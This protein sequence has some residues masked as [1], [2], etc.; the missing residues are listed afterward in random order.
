MIGIFL[1]AAADAVNA[2]PD[3]GGDSLWKSGA[4]ALG[5]MLLMKLF[6][7]VSGWID[8]KGK[9]WINEHF[10]QLQEKLNSNALLAQI[11]ADDAV[12]GILEASIPEVLLELSDTAQNDLKNGKFD[13]VDWQ[14]IGTRLWARV[15][16]QVMGGVHDYLKASSF[17]DGAVVAAWVMQRFFKKQEAAKKGLVP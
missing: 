13:A 6:S 10:A 2:V 15:Q 5:G 1:A 11:Q 7:W 14:G 16:P 12:I 9:E 17:K 8:G 4:L 3:A